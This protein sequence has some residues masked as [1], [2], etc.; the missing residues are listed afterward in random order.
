VPPGTSV[1]WTNDGPTVHT[2]TAD[3]GLFDSGIL[4]AGESYS[5]TFDEPGSYD[6]FCVPHPFMRGKV[7]VD[8]NAPPP[9]T[10]PTMPG[11]SDS[12]EPQ[13]EP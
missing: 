11:P 6:Y 4:E 8:A 1:T 13:P 7:I 3:A 5:F 12:P 10:G 2:A 9:S